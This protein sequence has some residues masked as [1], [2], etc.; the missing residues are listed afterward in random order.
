MSPNVVL[1]LRRLFLGVLSIIF[2]HSSCFSIFSLLFLIIYYNLNCTIM[3]CCFIYLVVA[4]T[5]FIIVVIIINYNKGLSCL[6]CSRVVIYKYNKQQIE[7]I[8]IIIDDFW[9]TFFFF[10]NKIYSSGQRRPAQNAKYRF[11]DKH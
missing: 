5:F 7:C 1:E 6:C 10:Y 2:L 3:Y 8:K 4:F 11:V 9:R